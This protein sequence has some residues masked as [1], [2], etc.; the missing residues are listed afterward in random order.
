VGRRIGRRAPGVEGQGE[1]KSASGHQRRAQVG[2]EGGLLDFERHVIDFWEKRVKKRG[3]GAF[4]YFI[5]AVEAKGGASGTH[6]R[7]SERK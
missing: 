1:G 5:L 3:E 6:G 7:G 4:P 2:Q